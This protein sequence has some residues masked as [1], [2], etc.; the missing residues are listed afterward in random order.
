MKQASRQW[1][2]ELAKFLTAKGFHQS[3]SN[4]SL[5]TREHAG[6]YIHILVYVDDLLVSDDDIDG[7]IKIEQALHD[8]FTIKDIGLA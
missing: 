2:L 6:K 4:Y 8:A 5:I 3:K 1:N 7:I